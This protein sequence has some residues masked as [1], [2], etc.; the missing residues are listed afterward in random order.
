MKKLLRK[1][2]NKPETDYYSDL[3]PRGIH[4]T[5]YYGTGDYNETW[6]HIRKE[7]RGINLPVL[8]IETNV[9]LKKVI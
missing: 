4:H 8:S 5:C 3:V 9:Q 6:E 1:W 7:T 2:L